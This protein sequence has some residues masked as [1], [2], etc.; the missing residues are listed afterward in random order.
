MSCIPIS[1]NMNFKPLTQFIKLKHLKSG[2][3][4]LKNVFL[5]IL[6]HF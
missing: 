5:G 4:E 2:L 1:Q 6:A 3:K